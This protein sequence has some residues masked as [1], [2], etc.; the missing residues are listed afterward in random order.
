MTIAAERFAGVRFE[1]PPRATAV[2]ASRTQA[3]TRPAPSSSRAVT[4]S[5]VDKGFHVASRAGEFVGS[6]DSTA[7]GHFIAFDATSAPIG[8]YASFVEARSAVTGWVPEGSRERERRVARAFMP[9]ATSAGIV[10]GA[11]AAIGALLTAI[12]A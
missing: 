2:R 9:V 4:W 12:P 1:R 5:T 3:P 11:T 10:A 7:D 6:I 8:R